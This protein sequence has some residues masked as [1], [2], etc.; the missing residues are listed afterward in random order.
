VRLVIDAGVATKWVF[1]ETG[2]DLA[3]GIRERFR[4]GELHLLAPDLFV[5]EIASV[6]WK[7]SVLLGEVSS[8]LAAV[9]LRLLLESA[10]ELV[11]SRLLAERAFELSRV[12][13]RSTHDCLYVALA[14]EE[15]CDFVTADEKLVAALRPI[16]P[17]VVALSAFGGRD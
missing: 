10:P 15:R 17:C 3:L 16:L 7:K 4:K 6:A 8:D 13:R 14:L 11:E 5:P 12:H 2:S 9:A 1:P